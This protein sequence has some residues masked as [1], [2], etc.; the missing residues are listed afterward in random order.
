MRNFVMSALAYS[1]CVAWAAAL[2]QTATPSSSQG[3]PTAT[4]SAAPASQII[5]PPPNY[6]FPSGQKYVYTVEWHLFTA[7]NAT[8]RLESSGTEQHVAATA[9]STGV[10]NVLY[11]VHDRFEAWFSPHSF[12]SLHVTK[13]T[14]EGSHKRDTTIVFDYARRK[15]VLDEKNLK[16]AELKHAQNDIPTCVTDVVSGFYYLASLPLQTGDSYTFSLNDGGKTADVTAKVE[17]RERVKVPLGTY[18]TIRVKAEAISG[19]MKGK[20][21]VFVWFT[22]DANRTPVQM[23]SKL[24]WGTL[25]FRMQRL[26]KQ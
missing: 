19:P 24:G 8:V 23:R 7:G 26:D 15:S 9:D 13:H 17:A 16:T 14:E 11:K 18:Q 22:D 20:G 10:V 1:L 5:P 2:G 21:S 3:A 25:L 4:V 12:C 6:Q